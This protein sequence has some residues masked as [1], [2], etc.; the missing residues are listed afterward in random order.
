[1]ED[2]QIGRV[3]KK[4][5]EVGLQAIT[6]GEFRRS[7]WHLDFLWGLDGIT[8]WDMGSGVAFAATATRAEGVKVDGKLGFSSHPM[9]EHFKFVATHTNRTPKITIPSPSAI[10]GRP[11]KTPINKGIYPDLDS[12][13]A[14]FR[15]LYSP[16]VGLFRLPRRMRAKAA[17][18]PCFCRSSP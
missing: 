6:D 1:V 4:Q 8:K 11:I 7:W 13:G 14:S 18:Q 12:C 2:R 10:Y 5:E 3:I 15:A 9:I 17:L 16:S